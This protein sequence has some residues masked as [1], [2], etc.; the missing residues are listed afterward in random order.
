MTKRS[1]EASEDD[2][3][4]IFG[5]WGKYGGENDTQTRE[6]PFGAIGPSPCP[7]DRFACAG[8]AGAGADKLRSP[9]RTISDLGARLDSGGSSGVSVQLCPSLCFYCLF[10]RQ[11]M[12]LM[13]FSLAEFSPGFPLQRMSRRPSEKDLL[14]TPAAI[15]IM[16]WESHV[17]DSLG[18][19]LRTLLWSNCRFG[20]APLV[21]FFRR[22]PDRR[23][24]AWWSPVFLSFSSN[25]NLECSGLTWRGR[26]K[27]LDRLAHAASWLVGVL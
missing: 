6:T 10:H 23:R 4:G 17:V 3:L 5:S 12:L 19:R 8:R 15:I 14:D 25:G 18:M 16:G 11:M 13:F 26:V 1:Q 20:G 2:Y 27:M 21:R 24:G 22:L 7:A 9:T